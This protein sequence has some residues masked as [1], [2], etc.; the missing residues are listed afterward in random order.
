MVKKYSNT[1]YATRVII[2]KI[3]KLLITYFTNVQKMKQLDD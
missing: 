2:K 1:H 3:L